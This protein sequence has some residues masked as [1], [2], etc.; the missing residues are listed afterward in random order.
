MNENC[1][2]LKESFGLPLGVMLLTPFA[3]APT[4]TLSLK[5]HFVFLLSIDRDWIPCCPM[6]KVQEPNVAIVAIEALVVQIMDIRLVVKHR[7]PRP[8]I[9]TVVR[10]C[11]H[12]GV[13]NPAAI[14]EGVE[15]HGSGY[16][17][18]CPQIAD[19]HLKR[20]AVD[21]SKSERSGVFVMLFVKLPIP[22]R[23]V[24]ETVRVVKNYLVPEEAHNE[25][26]QLFALAGQALWK[27]EA[28]RTTSPNSM[29]R[30]CHTEQKSK[31]KIH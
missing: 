17:K 25:A 6:H 11:A 16:A 20:C 18:K 23:L 24:H 14:E 30:L 10:L 7:Y 5:S 19:Q 2:L 4:L 1:S 13:Y 9:S 28:L 29:R 15:A 21:G 12:D 8:P 3:E 27:T 22:V 26:H 31:H